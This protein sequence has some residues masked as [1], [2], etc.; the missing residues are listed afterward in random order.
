MLRGTCRLHGT[1]NLIGGIAVYLSGFSEPL[2][3]G[4]G[5]CTYCNGRERKAAR[6]PKNLT[7]WWW[8]TCQERVGGDAVLLLWG[9]DGW[10]TNSPEKLPFCFMK[11]SCTG[12]TFCC[13][14]TS[15]PPQY[16]LL[17]WSSEN[18]KTGMDHI[19]SCCLMCIQH[20]GNYNGLNRRLIGFSRFIE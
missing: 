6:A 2:N 1:E 16:M 3:S 4:I 5:D 7:A 9:H 10:A 13:C 18:F 15:H 11:E 20:E 12:H 8:P 19:F 17:L 14:F